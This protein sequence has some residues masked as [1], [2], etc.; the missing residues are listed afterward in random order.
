MYS[1]SP[2]DFYGTGATLP[3]PSTSRQNAT[4]EN[5]PPPSSSFS[6]PLR[7]TSHSF[8][9]SP[10]RYQPYANSSPIRPSSP[11][12]AP[13]LKR[14]ATLHLNPSQ[15]QARLDEANSKRGGNEQEA[16]PELRRVGK[17]RERD[18]NRNAR[19]RAETQE[20]LSQVFGDR[21]LSVDVGVSLLAFYGLKVDG[22]N[23]RAKQIGYWKCT[24]CGIVKPKPKHEGGHIQSHYNSK[25][26]RTYA[27]KHQVPK[28]S[29]P[30]PGLTWK[31][32]REALRSLDHNTQV[33][34]AFNTSPIRPPLPPSNNNLRQS[35]PTTSSSGTQLTSSTSP[36]SLSFPSLPSAHLP[37][38]H[39]PPQPIFPQTSSPFSSLANA[40]S[41]HTVSSGK[42]HTS[43]SK[44]TCRGVVVP[45][46]QNKTFLD[47]EGVSTE[48]QYVTTLSTED[49]S[50]R[51]QSRLCLAKGTQ[52][53]AGNSCIRCELLLGRTSI[54]ALKDAGRA[55]TGKGL[56]LQQ[57]SFNQ[58]VD[59]IKSRNAALKHSFFKVRKLL[60]SNTSC[61]KQNALFK[62]IL[63]TIASC[64]RNIRVEH[65]I[66]TSLKHRD[67]LL[68]I[69]R[70]LVRA[71]AL[72]LNGRGWDESELAAAAIMKVT[73]GPPATAALRGAFGGPAEETIRKLTRAVQFKP[74]HGSPE[75]Y[76]DDTEH[77]LKLQG[78][79]RLPEN[80]RKSTHS[81]ATMGGD[82]TTASGHLCYAAKFRLVSDLCLEHSSS[83]K[84]T[85]DTIDDVE[86]IG[87]AIKT[88]TEEKTTGAHRARYITTLI[89]RTEGRNIYFSIYGSCGTGQTHQVEGP[90]WDAVFERAREILGHHGIELL[91]EESDG[92][93]SRRHRNHHN[94]NW[95]EITPEHELYKGTSVLVGFTMRIAKDGRRFFFDIRNLIKRVRTGIARP[96]GFSVGDTSVRSE[97]IMRHAV[98][99]EPN[100][101]R[102]SLLV[103][104][105]PSDAMR[106]PAAFSL[107]RLLSSLPF[108]EEMDSLKTR[109]AS[110]V[111]ERAAI[112]F[113]G[114]TAH[115]IASPLYTSSL[116]LKEGLTNWCEAGRL[117]LIHHF[118]NP[119]NGLQTKIYD[120]FTT[121]LHSTI[122]LI[123]HLQLV[124]SNLLVHLSEI[125]TNYVEE[126]FAAL[127]DRHENDT[128]L[129]VGKVATELGHIAL[130]AQLLDAHPNLRKRK[131]DRRDVDSNPADAD[132]GHIK[133]FSSANHAVGSVDVLECWNEG[134]WKRAFA[135]ARAH[136]LP[137]EKLSELEGRLRSGESDLRRPFGRFVMWSPADQKRYETER[138]RDPSSRSRASA[139]ERT[140]S[141]IDAEAEVPLNEAI[142]TEEDDEALLAAEAEERTRLEHLFVDQDDAFRA[143]SRFLPQD[144]SSSELDD[145]EEAEDDL[146]DATFEEQLERVA[147]GGGFEENSQVL[148][149]T[150]LSDVVLIAGSS[151]QEERDWARVVTEEELININGQS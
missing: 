63:Q 82:E 116:S 41:S 144:G 25:S 125:G 43:L 2:Q 135:T 118:V 74:S 81:Y 26:C 108:E 68:T 19:R 124:D 56:P 146:E 73:G 98:D 136:F 64:G 107:A 42:E 120:D 49:G 30:H 50:A 103:M 148:G 53:L 18:V 21:V 34:F 86:V 147:A 87:E 77:H 110:Y 91:G 35:P 78:F 101:Q 52:V 36:S 109:G 126:T 20:V 66:K 149:Q 113:V 95:M 129:T 134:F 71:K 131:K 97:T 12:R 9:S 83:L 145:L 17:E 84:A 29:L 60:R 27:V 47:L 28:E 14:P 54:K 122:S 102:S 119:S 94:S 114:Q 115:L 90:L 79:P 11:L 111:R 139:H 33:P 61:S 39:Q 1:I 92:D 89:G 32:G 130:L 93:S 3:R 75:S 38:A 13:S 46:A 65:H 133:D 150:D 140:S 85:I 112:H 58:L 132:R 22:A 37:S 127:R 141:E 105:M 69:A 104:I 117:L 5:A 106:C 8:L 143:P 57:R 16:R 10:P 44:V 151:E 4:N 128:T 6:S 62:K 80:E 96:E 88:G 23:E 72:G 137:E 24:L 55:R 31:A 138:A 45:M 40:K 100:V 70:K 99:A 7:R 15:P 76:A 59:G 51:I 142:P 67:G 121:T 123:L 48:A